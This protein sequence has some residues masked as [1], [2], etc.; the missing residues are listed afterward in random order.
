MDDINGWNFYK[1]SNVVYNFRSSTED[2]HGTHCAGT[3]IGYDEENDWSGIAGGISQIRVM[4]IKILGGIDGTGTFQ[5]L[6]EGIKYA[7]KN[8][9]VICNLSIGTEQWNEELYQV[10][11]QS[12]MLFVV[13]AGNGGGGTH[14]RGEDL[15]YN[16]RYPACYDLE[17]MIV[18]SN[19]KCDGTLHYSSFYGKNYADVAAPGT[20][21]YST[22]TIKEGYEMMTGTSMAVPMVSGIAALL[23]AQQEDWDI[24]YVKEAILNSCKTTEV[25][26]DFVR[27][28]GIPDVTAAIKYSG[29]SDKEELVPDKEESNQEELM[30]DKEESN[31][32]ELVPDKEESNQEEL[33]PDKDKTENVQA[34]INKNPE[35][36]LPPVIREETPT[37]IQKPGKTDK[38]KV[39]KVKVRKVKYKRTKKQIILSMQVKGNYK[40]QL[41]VQQKKGKK[42]VQSKKIICKSK[43]WKTVRF[44]LKRTHGNIRVVKI[45]HYRKYKGKTYYGAWRRLKR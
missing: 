25:F 43:K 33:M 34:D 44:K 31:Q 1:N 5:D 36:S 13:A 35:V 28:G 2:A 11:K 7:E 32:E 16:P 21:I 6:I 26:Y 22:S 10:M 18:V 39:P 30:P 29:E 23:Y 41:I 27:T 45:R 19:M 4:P 24:L 15:E 40:A 42:K 14:G 12:N 17:N 37:Q 3:I 20:R 38:I 8:G 9:A